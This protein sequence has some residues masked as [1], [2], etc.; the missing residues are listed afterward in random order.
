MKK[1]KKIINLSKR[2]FNLYFLFSFL[3]F[4]LPKNN[5]IS[6]NNSIKKIKYKKFVWHLNEKD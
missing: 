4:V 3:F 6:K 1:N 2:K 5:I